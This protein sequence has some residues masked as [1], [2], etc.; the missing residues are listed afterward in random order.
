LSDRRP[1]QRERARPAVDEVEQEVQDAVDD[2]LD[3]ELD[4]NGREIVPRSS[5][6]RA[7]VD[8]LDEEDLP[9]WAD[10]FVRVLDDGVR[11]PGTQVRFGLDAVLGFFLPTL[12]DA[13]T[14]AGS[15]ALLF[16][17]LRE[18]VPTVAIGRMLINI[19]IDTII[20]SIPIAGDIFDVFFRAN[21]RNLEIIERYHSDPDAAPSA[22]D[23]VLVLGGLLLILVGIALPFLFATVLAGVFTSTAQ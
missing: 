2:V 9:N 7:R 19:F 5:R 22:L 23:Y 12:G 16:L 8:E 20:G 21:R 15:A 4:R 14:G 3:R 17:A 13:V 1:R 6:T 11:V 10:K 18:R